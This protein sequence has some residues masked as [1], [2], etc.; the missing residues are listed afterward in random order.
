MFAW[1][2]QSTVCYAYLADVS[3]ID[4]YGNW[5]ELQTSTWATRGWTLQELL[6]P[7]NVVFYSGQWRKIG[8]KS[9]LKRTLSVMT[10]INQIYL[11]MEKPIVRA[12]IAERMSWA[13]RR[14]TTRP[15]D[16]AYCLLG[17]F[18]VNLPML[19]GEGA[20]AFIRLQVDFQTQGKS[21]N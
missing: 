2:Q 5:P 18:D 10:G 15:E 9:S 6:A 3:F 13:A 14:Q 16:I 1:Y 7:R 20:K 19:Y 21:R 17:L 8:T 11:A 12:S 4:Q